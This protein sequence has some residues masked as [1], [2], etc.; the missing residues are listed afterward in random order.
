[1]NKPATICFAFTFFILGSYAQLDS[2]MQLIDTRMDEFE[3]CINKYGVTDTSEFCMEPLDFIRDLDDRERKY[4]SAKFKRIYKDYEY[5]V[6]QEHFKGYLRN[7]LLK[8]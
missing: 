7:E 4:A 3:E 5:G 6:I 2:V 8:P 1:M